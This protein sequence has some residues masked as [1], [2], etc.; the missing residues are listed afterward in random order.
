[1]IL[2]GTGIIDSRRTA[3]EVAAN[4]VANNG[5][6]YY[7]EDGFNWFSGSGQAIFSPQKVAWNGSYWLMGGVSNSSNNTVLTKSTDGKNW[8]KI[9]ITTLSGMSGCTAINSIIWDGSKWMIGTNI[10]VWV[11][12]NG[13]TWSQSGFAGIVRSIAYS[14]SIYV[15]GLNTNSVRWS[16]NGTSWSSPSSGSF[17]AQNV[18]SVGWD[19]T[20]FWACLQN[21]GAGQYAAYRSSNGSTWFASIPA[22][23][24]FSKS[25]FGGMSLI[26][27]S[28]GART[29]GFG[30]TSAS[31]FM[32]GNLPTAGSVTW[33]GLVAYPGGFGANGFVSDCF[34]D[35]TKF[36][37]IG[38]SST[39][40]IAYSYDG[41]SWFNTS[42]VAA[43]SQYGCIAGKSNKTVQP[44]F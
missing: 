36:L 35:G 13:D 1:M 30:L 21:N 27:R 3:P 9:P 33:A 16:N 10:G 32:V 39:L 43:N 42:G 20:N 23:T 2:T 19:G 31:P 17:T 18:Y 14:G 34:Y 7:S 15:I 4:Y 24:V 8:T 5:T 41:N 26:A 29:L 38:R 40:P 12:T 28:G 44:Q 25:G 6:Y 22:T 37:A 11:S